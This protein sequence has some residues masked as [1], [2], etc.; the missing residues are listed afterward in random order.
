MLGA[1]SSYMLQNFLGLP[2]ILCVPASFVIVAAVGLVLERGLIRYLYKRPLDTLLATFGVSLVLMQG[3][4]LLFGSDPKYLAVP[5]FFSSNFQLGLRQHLGVPGCRPVHHHGAGGGIVGAVL[6]NPVRRPGPRR[7][8]E[9]GNGGFVR[10]QLRPDLHA[11]LCARRGACGDRRVAVRRAQYRAAHHG[12]ELCGAGLPGRRRRRR[13]ARAAAWSPAARPAS[14]SRSSPISPTT[15][16][17][18]SSC[19]C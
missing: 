13:D 12:R 19:S 18:A 7:D 10:H 9:Q 11:H 2:F 6:Q 8:A 14:C 16:S 15:L 1:Y 3:V 17:P 4:R 5:S